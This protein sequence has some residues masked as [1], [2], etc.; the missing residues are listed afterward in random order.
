MWE[1]FRSLLKGKTSGAESPH[2]TNRRRP[3]DPLGNLS[4]IAAPPPVE[5]RD[6]SKIYHRHTLE[7]NLRRN[8][9]GEDIDAEDA[10][11]D[12]LIRHHTLEENIALAK[13]LSKEM[14]RQSEELRRRSVDNELVKG[15]GDEGR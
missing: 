10:N 15:V 13:E 14:S 3:S 1:K 5:N 2:R 11:E 7:E 8:S 4:E 6:D 12:I 9:R